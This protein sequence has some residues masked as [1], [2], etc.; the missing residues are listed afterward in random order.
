MSRYRSWRRVSPSALQLST[1][2]AT[3]G[4]CRDQ[5]TA[6]VSRESLTPESRGQRAACG[7]EK[8]K[9]EGSSL[10][11]NTLWGDFAG[12]AAADSPRIRR[13]RKNSPDPASTE[14]NSQTEAGK[15]VWP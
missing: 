1:R 3:S 13:R 9:S 5:T 8:G 10:F 15:G 2:G 7:K 12:Q 14:P 4:E 6:A 11:R